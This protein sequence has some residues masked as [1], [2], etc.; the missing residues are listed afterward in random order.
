MLRSF[1]PRAR[2]NRD[3]FDL[4]VAFTWHL[5]AGVLRMVDPLIARANGLT[6]LLWTNPRTR[7]RR[8]KESMRLQLAGAPGAAATPEEA[9]ARA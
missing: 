2:S 1:E 8:E 4:A 3:H 6:F 7:L 9:G 5:A